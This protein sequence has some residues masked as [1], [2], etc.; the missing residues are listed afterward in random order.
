MLRQHGVT[1]LLKAN[2]Q[3]KD[4]RKKFRICRRLSN[5]RFTVW[6]HRRLHP[7]LLRM[8]EWTMMASAI[9][10]R[11]VQGRAPF[12]LVT[13]YVFPLCLRP[14]RI[15]VAGSRQAVWM[16]CWSATTNLDGFHIKMNTGLWTI[17]IGIYI[18]KLFL[19]EQV[20]QHTP[21]QLYACRG[22]SFSFTCLTPTCVLV[23]TGNSFLFL[24]ILV[25]CI[26]TIKHR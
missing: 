14:L 24:R 3:V 4:D 15:C 13:S 18:I 8:H 6:A 20:V 10:R 9:K 5:A 25:G 17:S 2:F 16:L 7:N 1:E 26:R 11:R 19:I 12:Q 23:A 21:T 22:F